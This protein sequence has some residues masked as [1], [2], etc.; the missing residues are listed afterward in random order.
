[1]GIDVAEEVFEAARLRGQPDQFR[2]C[3]VG[4]AV[5]SAG[6]ARPAASA[7]RPM[8]RRADR[9]DVVGVM[10]ALGMVCVLCSGLGTGGDA[11][12]ALASQVDGCEAREDIWCR[13]GNH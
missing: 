9:G 12:R 8:P 4:A 5:A 2:I 13:P 3:V 6:T 7:V 11:R 1:M 10:V